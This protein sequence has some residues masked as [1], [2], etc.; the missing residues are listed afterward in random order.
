MSRPHRFDANQ[1]TRTVLT[2]SAALLCGL[3]LRLGDVAMK[4][5]TATS[6]VASEAAASGSVAAPEQAVSVPVQQVGQPQSAPDQGAVTPLPDSELAPARQRDGRE[7]DEGD[8][9]YEEESYRYTSLGMDIPENATTAGGVS[10]GSVTTPPGQAVGGYYSAR[11][12]V[13]PRAVTRGS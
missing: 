4:K 5:P 9:G 7:E 11:P 10:S 8:D 6:P 2:L 12:P 3:G 1:A 13:R